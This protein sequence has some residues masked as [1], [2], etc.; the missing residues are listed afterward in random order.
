MS[1]MGLQKVTKL[2]VYIKERNILTYPT[3]FF[4]PF[5]IKCRFANAIIAIGA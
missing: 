4:V 2:C 3:Y 1:F 5:G